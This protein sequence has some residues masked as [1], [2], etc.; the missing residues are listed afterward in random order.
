[1]GFS[2]VNGQFDSHIPLSDR[3]LNYGDGIFTSIR[4]SDGQP[5]LWDYHI[6]RLVTGCRRLKFT[7]VAQRICQQLTA[8]WQL[9]HDELQ[10]EITDKPLTG[11]LKIVISRGSAGRGYRPPAICSYRRILSWHK[12]PA[13]PEHYYQQGVRI[14]LCQTSLAN[15]PLLAGIKHLNR[16][17]QVLARAEWDDPEIAEGL[18]LD[19]QGHVICATQ[20]N[21]FWRQGKQI[22][23]PELE[24][25][26]ITGVMRRHIMNY[27]ARQGWP[28]LET[29][30][31]LKTLLKAEEAWLSNAV[32]GVWPVRQIMGQ[33]FT[34]GPVANKLVEHLKSIF[35]DK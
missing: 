17:E 18:M 25:T 2:L 11:V 3:G 6:E 5:L 22:Y 15:N 12:L 35:K 29:R 26:G 9:L 8:D 28:V 14:R 7:L 30:C 20:S 10:A 31:K 21:V 27:L 24:Q 1:M 4:V 34:P 23:T 32:I 33:P 16:L 13:I 19:S